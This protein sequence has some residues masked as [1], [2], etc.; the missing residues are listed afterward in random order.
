MPFYNHF[1]DWNGLEVDV[2]PAEPRRK[3]FRIWPYFVGQRIQLELRVKKVTPIEKNDLQFHFVEKMADED[4]P[5]MVAPTFLPEQS[6]D[7]EKVFELRNGSRISGK[8]EV[9]YWLSSRG[10]NV[11]HEPIFSAEAISLDPMV[12][13]LLV[14]ISGPL[15]GFIFGL[16][17]GLLLGS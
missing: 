2:Q 4:K 10:Y 17:L 15:L 5:R 12:I 16:L 11:D 6:T 8:G 13:P 7:H 9:K 1:L 3:K 14:M